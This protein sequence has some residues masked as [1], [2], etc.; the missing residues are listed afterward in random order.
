MKQNFLRSLFYVVNLIFPIVM[1]TVLTIW[2]FNIPAECGERMSVGVTLL[3]AVTVFMMLVTEMIPESSEAVPLVGRFFIFCMI[4]MFF[5]NIA[6]G[7]V[8]GMYNRTGRDTPMG[9]WTRSYVLERISYV[10]GVR[11]HDHQSP[12]VRQTSQENVNY[13]S[14]TMTCANIANHSVC[15]M[16]GERQKKSESELDEVDAN[17]IYEVVPNKEDEA[18]KYTTT[19]E[20]SN[21]PE[22]EWRVVGKTLDRMFFMFFMSVF[23]IG[24]I[25]C[26]GMTFD[27][28]PKDSGYVTC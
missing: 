19:G 11:N 18:G 9:S 13:E 27:N 8:N 23:I 4:T 25:W 6:V 5:I 16:G 1:I 24:S 22:E 21:T 7:F 26:F 17:R 20:H 2:V 12:T 3:L 14:T 10:I 15:F 28:K